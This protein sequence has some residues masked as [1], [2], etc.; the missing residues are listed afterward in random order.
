MQKC[1]VHSIKTRN[2][3]IYTDGDRISNTLYTRCTHCYIKPGREPNSKFKAAEK[4]RTRAKAPPASVCSQLPL[5]HFKSTAPGR[6]GRH[7]WLNTRR[8]TPKFHTA[9]F[10]LGTRRSTVIFFWIFKIRI[11]VQKWQCVV[12]LFFIRLTGKVFKSLSYLR[13]SV[14]LT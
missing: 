11:T 8:K 9:T 12:L 13:F 1:T 10:G 14:V 2:S 5:R 7:H 6:A 3:Y 4:C